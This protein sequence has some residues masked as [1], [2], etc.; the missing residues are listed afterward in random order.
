MQRLLDKVSGNYIL[1]SI[2]GIIHFAFYGV[3]SHQVAKCE[4]LYGS[5]PPDMRFGYT[6]DD[7]Y[8]IYEIWGEEG[9]KEYIRSAYY[10]Y[11]YIPTYVLFMNAL[12]LRACRRSKWD[13]KFVPQLAW[14]MLVADYTETS[15]HIAGCNRYPDRLDKSVVM[16]GDL[17]NRIKFVCLCVVG[18]LIVAGLIIRAYLWPLM[19]FNTPTSDQNAQVAANNNNTSAAAADAGKRSKKGKISNKKKKN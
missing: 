14:L 11:M 1:L 13:D 6:A 8:S 7:L 3:Y 16:F 5:K 18:T 17:F 2:S 12:L 4:D 10:D 15:I 19:M 9:C